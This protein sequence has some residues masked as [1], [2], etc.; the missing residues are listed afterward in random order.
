V[1]SDKPATPPE[2]H[3]STP[4]DSTSSDGT[5]NDAASPSAAAQVPRSQY[6]SLPGEEG[7]RFLICPKALVLV[8][9]FTREAYVAYSLGAPN[10]TNLQFLIRLNVLNA[11]ARNGINMGVPVDGLCEEEAISTFNAKGPLR[12]ADSEM[13]GFV[14]TDCPESL[15]PTDIQ[16][17]IVHHPWI[18]LFPFPK[19]RENVILG[20][21]A[22]LVDDDELCWDMLGSYCPDIDEDVA[23][24]VWGNGESNM[25]WE[26][27]VGF[28]KKW[29]WLLRGC[30]EML[31]STNYWR[32]KRGEKRIIFEIP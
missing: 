15:R 10:P 25:G 4:S 8:R 3:Y 29:A 30:E 32:E 21:D 1:K 23:V 5:T 20:I 16:R 24:L 26:L 7:T 22:G 17:A 19:F 14:R 12:L 31:Q 9:R 28:L 2:S 18:D 27:S 11:L 6:C 13:D